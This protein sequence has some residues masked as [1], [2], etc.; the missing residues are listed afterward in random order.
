MTH[1]RITVGLMALLLA[2]LAGV[3]AIHVSAAGPVIGTVTVGATPLGIAVDARAG[4]AFVVNNGDDSITV[5]DTRSGAVLRTVPVG[6]GPTA[7]VVD[8]R[9]GR[10][11]VVDSN[12]S[13]SEQTGQFYL[14]RPQFSGAP[15]LAMLQASNGRLLGETPA[16]VSLAGAAVDERHGRIFVSM[17]GET[18]PFM[19][20][21]GSVGILRS[22][23]GGDAVTPLADV[24]GTPLAMAADGQANRVI[25]A[26]DAQG[27]TLSVIDAA[28]GRLVRR[29]V[30]G[31]FLPGQALAVDER[32]GRVF[33]ITSD[34]AANKGS[35]C[36]FSTQ[37]GQLLR[38]VALDSAA[39]A[40]V[41]DEQSGHVFVTTIGPTTSLTIGASIHPAP[42]MTWGFR[43]RLRPLSVPVSIGAG[44][45]VTLDAR[46][47]AVLHSSRVG[48]GPEPEAVDSRHHHLLVASVGA[49]DRLGTPVGPGSIAV[50]D[51]RTGI[52]LRTVTVGIAPG[53]VAVDE[54]A[55]RALV[56]NVGGAVHVSDTWGWVPS[57]LRQRVQLL[58]QGPR[59]RTMPGSVTVLDLARL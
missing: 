25:V 15:G 2:V 36:M 43:P 35:V 29:A 52:L 57:W 59:T 50:V 58:R 44:S 39:A 49:M 46:S 30:V 1:R 33:A 27:G 51:T 37:T 14:L 12:S 10:V 13:A 28:S 47:G 26:S 38:T 3:V 5:L 21:D 40:V 18:L 9:G 56:L 20:S 41:A 8:E 45:V 34:L 16:S 32:T 42:G 31:P 54:R 17:T 19:D 22:G 6:A 23:R 55:G 11:V 24:P 53:D 7:A 48:I 4:R